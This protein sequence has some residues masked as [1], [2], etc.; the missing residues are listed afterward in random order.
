M[1]NFK[2]LSIIGGVI[3]AT[4]SASAQAEIT[5]LDK[6]KQS[7]SL[8][9]PLSLQVGGSIRPEWIFENT[10]NKTHGD[11]SGHDGGT[12]FRFTGNYALT[13]HTAVVGYYELGVNTY[14]L[15]GINSGYDKG[16]N[17]LD[18]RQL[19]YGLQDD[20]YGK[21][22]FGQQYGVYYSIVG[23]KSDVWDN[24]GHAAGEGVGVSANYD[25]TY[26]AR[27]SIQYE[28]TWG[29]IRLVANYLLPDTELNLGDNLHYRRD[30]GGGIGVDYTITPKLS[31]STAYSFNR[32]KIIDSSADDQKHYNQQISGTALTWQPGNWYLV[33][34]AN[35]YDN[36]VP[37]HHSDINQDN[38]FAG[39]G[40]GVESFV[41][42]TFTLNQPLLKS[43]QPYF[44]ADSLT[45][46]GH[47]NYNAHNQYLG[48]A[49]V[50]GHGLSVYIERTLAHAPDE[51]DQTWMTFYYD[52]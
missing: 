48:A 38:Y 34:T 17:L 43:V 41:G 28:N 42:Y 11:S 1:G 50:F 14:H 39:S 51:N 5:I 16:T 2:T 23:I 46:K 49:L 26:A 25:G 44:A 27:K 7:D 29:P 8:L 20:R 13:D 35:Y 12:R 24:D 47:E 10:E 40:Y 6:D 37:S 19:F 9:A 45:L 18:K 30:G 31:W 52:F 33:T 32:A 22:T 36:F 3:L 4:L 21:L 15:F